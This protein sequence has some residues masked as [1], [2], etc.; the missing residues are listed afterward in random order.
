MRELIP[1][2]VLLCLSISTHAQSAYQEIREGNELF[3]NNSF[4]AAAKKYQESIS[5]DIEPLESS[6]NLGNALYRQEKYEDAARYFNQAANKT[7]DKEIRSNA[8]HNLGN[9]F[10]KE[11]KYEEMK[12]SFDLVL[13]N[14]NIYLLTF[15]V[16]R[17]Q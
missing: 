12:S 9:S 10:L 2:V 13:P 8:Y 3:K 11:E 5:K 4:E 14:V 6:Y 17:F 1:I 15:L 16:N 7:E